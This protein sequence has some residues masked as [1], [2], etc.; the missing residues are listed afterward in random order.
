MQDGLGVIPK[1]HCALFL[2]A[3]PAPCALCSL[4]PDIEG[5]RTI[6]SITVKRER[7]T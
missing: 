5:V 4:R 6:P 7:E 2:F 1:A 3:S